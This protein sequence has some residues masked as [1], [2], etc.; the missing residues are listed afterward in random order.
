M[1]PIIHLDRRGSGGG[2][3]GTG[4]NGQ[5]EF[6]AD[7]PIT[8][9]T[10]AVG[11]IYLVEKKTT[12]LGFTTY[13]S[14]LYIR[15]NNTGAL[16][17]WRRLNVK[18]QFT[19]SEFTIVSAVDTS[20]RAK[21]DVSLV[22]ASTTRTYTYP[23]KSGTFA[24][25]S[26]VTL[27]GLPSVLGQDNTTGTNDI[28]I[29]DGQ[30]IKASNGS[31]V[32]DPRFL[33][34]DNQIAIYTGS[35]TV[36]G[37]GTESWIDLN[38]DVLQFGHGKS[39]FS[40]A[41]FGATQTIFISS[42][43]SFFVNDIGILTLTESLAQL[44]FYKAN[45]TKIG[46]LGIVNNDVAPVTTAATPNFPVNGGSQSLNINTG[47]VNS[48]SLGGTGIEVKT[49]NSAY[50]NQIAYNTGLAGELIVN[51]TPSATD[52]TQT[53]QADDGVIALTKNIAKAFFAVDLDSAESS[54]SRVFAGG[55][56]TFTVTHNLDTLD[57]KPEVFRLSDGRTLGF[58]T[59][60]TG[61][62]TVEV[63]RNGNIADGLFRILI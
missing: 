38:V 26:D 51:H 28:S 35:H 53:H 6:R 18:V 29:D 43:S 44:Q 15:D 20:K 1:K 58:R 55:R 21:F 22:T 2:G 33:G 11:E 19:D 63:S 47:V 14:G 30:V 41:D 34:V 61:V 59:E 45:F 57:L 36:L 52:Y 39:F 48:I 31:A 54:V 12:L 3:T 17:D 8:L 40:M 16:S 46:V 50:C 24:L 4:W 23:D 56:T 9:G 7:L 27:Q 5:V 62:N 60:R 42:S 37:E 10:P 49:D 32:Y 13:Q 25:L